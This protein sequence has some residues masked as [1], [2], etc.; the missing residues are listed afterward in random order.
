MTFWLKSIICGLTFAAIM[1]T[2]FFLRVSG[3]AIVIIICCPFLLFFGATLFAKRLLSLYTTLIALLAA[4]V[5]GIDWYHEA[6]WVH[7]GGEADGLDII[8]VPVVQT[9]FGVIALLIA[10]AEWLITIR[11]QRST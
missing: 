8:A 6:F 2:A 3:A 10:F 1:G 11:L 7:H 9:V 5:V 4:V